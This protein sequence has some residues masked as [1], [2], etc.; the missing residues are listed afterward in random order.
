VTERKRQKRSRIE[1]ST[2]EAGRMKDANKEAEAERKGLE[3]YRRMRQRKKR[4]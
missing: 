2:F 4:G 1:R 3:S